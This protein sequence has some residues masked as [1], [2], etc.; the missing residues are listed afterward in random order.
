MLKKYETLNKLNQKRLVAVIRGKNAEDAVAIGQ[1]AING[2]IES[3]E[4]TLTT[5]NGLTAL[6]QLKKKEKTAVIGAGSV[7]DPETARLSIIYGADFIV[8]PNF[9]KAI[10]EVCNLYSIP[11]LPGCFTVTEITEALRSGVDVIKA[12]PGSVAGLGF[13]KSIHGPIPNVAI[14][15]TGGV[16]LQNVDE[17]LNQGAYAVGIGSV[18]TKGAE[19]GNY[20]AVEENAHAF[21][22]K[23]GV[24]NFS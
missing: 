5:P 16:N 9:S 20:H 14:M 23:V 17:W 22:D 24:L 10:S 18:L 1:A 11:Y 12:F 3:I 21:T 19:N 4:V 13:I 8:S 15:P 7:L 2:G 6:Q